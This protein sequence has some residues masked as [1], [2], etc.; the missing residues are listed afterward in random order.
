MNINLDQTV[1]KENKIPSLPQNGTS[2]IIICLVSR[3]ISLS[4]H[5]H[6]VQSQFQSISQW[7]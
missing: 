1:N 2:M 3:N 5:I 6:S 7:L 4:E